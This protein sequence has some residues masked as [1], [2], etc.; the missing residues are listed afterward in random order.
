MTRRW[1]P[2]ILLL[3]SAYALFEVALA[4]QAPAGTPPCT[5]QGNP[6]TT[7]YQFR[8]QMDRCEGIFDSRP[9]AAIGLSLASY[10]IGVP[11]AQR[12]AGQGEVIGLQVPAGSASQKEPAVTVQANGG[13]YKMTPLGLASPR[14]GWRS[15]Y[16]GAGVIRRENISLSQL[17]ATALISQS[18]Q[19]HQ[20]LPVKFAPAGAYNLA[21]TTNG[22]QRV[23]YVRIVN[24]NNQLVSDCAG[25]TRLERELHCR[26][27]ARNRPAG[28]YRL[29]ARST[30]GGTL[31]NENLLH[32]PSWLGR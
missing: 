11:L 22:A 4:T 30:E 10:T 18:G 14:A 15:F 21:I 2:H 27:E 17:H 1:F 7:D 13:D 8:Q 19:A 12:R 6:R 31:L 5:T 25:S 23:A 9:I 16:W 24:S 26:W 28:S 20:K 32:D 29:I 3:A